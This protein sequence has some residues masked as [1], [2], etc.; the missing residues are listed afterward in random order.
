MMREFKLILFYRGDDREIILCTGNVRFN[1]T[2]NDTAP[3]TNGEIKRRSKIIDPFDKPVG[4]L[5]RITMYRDL[6]TLPLDV[7]LPFGYRVEPWVEPM[8]PAYAAAMAVAFSDSP[9][10][11]YYP[12]LSSQ[13]G[14]LEMIT[15]IA[16]LPG[17]IMGA[18]WLIF[19]NREPC[20]LVLTGRSGTRGQGINRLVGIAPR[21]RR[22]K[23]GSQ[24]VTKAL[25]ALR[26]RRLDTASVTIS[27]VNRKGI[28]FFRKNKFQAETAREYL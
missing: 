7:P 24:I 15:E 2:E 22:I 16:S 20:G 23:V 25:W 18:S 4:G 28:R 13:D 3:M 11:E 14:C 5:V 19:F 1:V 21:H 17:F 12:K 6:G 8:I 27:G 10:L 26:D 9:E